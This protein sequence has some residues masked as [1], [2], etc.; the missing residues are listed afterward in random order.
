MA[1]FRLV[2]GDNGGVEDSFRLGSDGR[3]VFMFDTVGMDG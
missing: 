2:A 1:C 3:G